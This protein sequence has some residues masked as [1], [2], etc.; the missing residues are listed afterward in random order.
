MHLSFIDLHTYVA[1]QA[2][3]VQIV[4][5]IFLMLKRLYMHYNWN[6]IALAL[7]HYVCTLYN[8]CMYMYVELH[9][10]LHMLGNIAKH[11]H[12]LQF[13]KQ[14]KF[15]GVPQ[16]LKVEWNVLHR[17]TLYYYT[18]MY[19]HVVFNFG[20]IC[21]PQSSAVHASTGVFLSVVLFFLLSSRRPPH[22]A[23]QCVL[24]LAALLMAMVWLYLQASEVVAVLE[25][26]GLIFRVDTGTF[27]FFF[28]F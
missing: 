7:Q 13:H 19:I 4:F 12:I 20:L 25:S 10:H 5:M 23:V 26:F 27:F 15:C 16:Q 11:T 21:Q 28:S 8:V 1:M 22:W 2:S 9:M 17:N 14:N 24:A 6:G 18:Y 3:I